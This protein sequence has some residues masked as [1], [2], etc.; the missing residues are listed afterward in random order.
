MELREEARRREREG[1]RIR[2][3][4]E[5]LALD[6]R[7]VASRPEGARV[8][9]W[10]L[11]RGDIFNPVFQPGAGGAYY[12][13]KKAAALELWQLLGGVLERGA[14][15]EL[16]FG[17]EEERNEEAENSADGGG[18]GIYGRD[19]AWEAEPGGWS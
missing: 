5:R 12:A 2:R 17:G 18:E 3:G 9:R 7:A 8:F 13:G 19:T 15:V 10:L 4:R 16:A 11:R 14:F 6:L 1:E